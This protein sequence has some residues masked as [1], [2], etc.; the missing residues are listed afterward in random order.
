LSLTFRAV[1]V[2]A[3]VLYPE[4]ITTSQDTLL[5]IL[6]HNNDSNEVLWDPNILAL[7]YGNRK[8]CIV[9]SKETEIRKRITIFGSLKINTGPANLGIGS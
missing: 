2:A 4:H 8:T 3:A 5:F 9:N 7:H 6:M 1:I